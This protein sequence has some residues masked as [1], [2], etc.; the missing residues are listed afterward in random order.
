MPQYRADHMV[1]VLKR[2]G[3]FLVRQKGSHQ[4]YKNSEGIMVPLPF[5]GKKRTIPLGTALAIIKQSKIS[6]KEF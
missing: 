4:I 5:H 1:K 3:F 2:H 6:K